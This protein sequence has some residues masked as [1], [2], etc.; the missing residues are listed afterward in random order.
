MPKRV[1]VRYAQ[2]KVNGKQRIK[3]EIDPKKKFPLTI[4]V[5]Y[6]G[7]NGTGF[8]LVPVR[9]RHARAMCRWIL[10]HLPEEE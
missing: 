5:V 4:E 7:S 1:G 6:E 2:L 10:K 3:L 9:A 8:I